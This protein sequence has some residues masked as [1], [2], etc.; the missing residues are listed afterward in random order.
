[1]RDY[2]VTFRLKS[3]YQMFCIVHFKTEQESIDKIEKMVDVQYVIN[4]EKI[5]ERV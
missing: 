1:M 3:G 4:V 2:R 5:G